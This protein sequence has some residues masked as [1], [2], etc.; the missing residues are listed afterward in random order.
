MAAPTSAN[1]R[2]LKTLHNFNDVNFRNKCMSIKIVALRNRY[3][4]KTKHQID[5]PNATTQEKS[6]KMI[7]T[8]Q[9]VDEHLLNQPN[10]SD[11]SQNSTQRTHTSVC[12]RTMFKATS[13]T[14]GA[15]T[16]KRKFDIL[17]NH[18]MNHYTTMQR[19]EHIHNR[20]KT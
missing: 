4:A 18:I 10:P 8:Q 6:K 11:I 14:R 17:K 15:R 9:C 20:K 5:I 12:K 7:Q 16:K 3:V 13:K 2:F 19:E 1:R